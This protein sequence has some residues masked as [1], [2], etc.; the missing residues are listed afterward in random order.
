MAPDSGE[1]GENPEGT[2]C[3][4][5]TLPEH[6]L[7]TS[8]QPKATE[9]VAHVVLTGYPGKA[10]NDGRVRLYLGLDLQTYYEFS[11]DDFIHHWASD[12][13]NEN[14]PTNIAVKASATLNLVVGSVSS[15]A[16]AVLQGDIVSTFLADAIR[17]A[18]CECICSPTPPPPPCHQG[19]YGGR[20]GTERPKRRKRDGWS[21]E[22]E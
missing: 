19:S 20:R 3:E 14:S 18:C 17:L 15:A 16:A 1:G 10:T 7:V 11:R 9:P 6:P 8:L 5:E 21:E 2:G 22:P 13:N 12:P 4:A